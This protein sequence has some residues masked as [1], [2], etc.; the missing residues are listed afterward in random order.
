MRRVVTGVA[1]LAILAGCGGQDAGPVLERTT[2]N[3]AQLERATLDL[4][5]LTTPTGGDEGVGFALEGP[6]DL[7]GDGPLPVADLTYTRIA[8]E[9]RTTAGLLLTGEEAYVRAGGQA[10]VLGPEQTQTLRRGG[11][12]RDLAALGLDPAG[13]LLDAEVE[14]GA[15]VDGAPT[16]RVSGDLD[17]AA[18][19]TDLLQVARRAGAP[20]PELP[21]GAPDRLDDAVED[22]RLTILTGRDDRLLRRLELRANLRQAEELSDLLPGGGG[23]T[24]DASLRLGSL[25]EPVDV[26][27]PADARPLA[28]APAG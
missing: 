14:E 27:P 3:L 15:Q 5:V 2:A 10:F 8:G 25:R 17:L 23:L 7:G 20:A 13:W 9:Q 19:I 1:A 6:V 4:R 22:A 28:P 21:E 16:D 12:P 26:E 18:L 24:V 11:A